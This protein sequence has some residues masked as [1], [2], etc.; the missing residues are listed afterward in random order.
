MQSTYEPNPPT[1]LLRSDFLASISTSHIHIGLLKRLRRAQGLITQF[2]K[3]RTSLRRASEQV[4]QDYSSKSQSH[5]Q[6][7]AT[8]RKQT[9]NVVYGLNAQIAV[10]KEVTM[11]AKRQFILVRDTEGV[12]QGT[13]P[14]T[15]DPISIE[16]ESGFHVPGKGKVVVWSG[17]DVKALVFSRI[18]EDDDE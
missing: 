14:G 13:P 17:P 1:D 3:L 12:I 10:L 16:M 8:F 6:P 7:I 15:A 11:R 18:S 2:T 4:L 9:E 5:E